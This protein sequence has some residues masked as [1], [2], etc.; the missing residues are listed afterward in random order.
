MDDGTLKISL[1]LSKTLFRVEDDKYEVH[2]SLYTEPKKGILVWQE[3]QV[4]VTVK[5]ATVRLSL[6]AKRPVRNLL[7]VYH[8]LYL[9]LDFQHSD[10]KVQF[11]HRFKL[12]DKSDLVLMKTP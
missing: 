3:T 8:T 4:D 7:W 12:E 6:G 1:D 9:E 11:D 10:K 5:D 2:L